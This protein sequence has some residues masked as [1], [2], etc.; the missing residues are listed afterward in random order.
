M[1]FRYEKFAAIALSQW[2]TGRGYEVCLSVPGPIEDLI[3]RDELGGVRPPELSAEDFADP[4]RRYEIY[5]DSP[6]NVDLVARRGEELWLVEA[7]GL[8]KGGSA[9]GTIAQAIGQVVMMMAPGI[10]ALRYGILLPRED[11]FVQAVE[12]ILPDNPLLNR[13]DFFIFWVSS[14]GVIDSERAESISPRE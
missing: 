3:E 6:G 11:R 4:Q 9:P 10:P 5:Y 12:K 2:F 8:A 13:D 1:E 14:D 7:K